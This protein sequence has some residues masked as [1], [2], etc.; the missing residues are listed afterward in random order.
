MRQRAF[1]LVELLV[2]IAIIGLLASIVLVV[3]GSAREKA[4]IAK[5][6]QFASNI[7]QVLG[8]EAAGIWDFDD[9]QDPTMDTSGSGNDGTIISAVFIDDTPSN[10]GHALSFN[11]SGAYVDCGNDDSLNFG[12]GDFTISVWVKTSGGSESWAGIVHKGAIT[13]GENYDPA[14]SIDLEYSGSA[15]DNNNSFFQA[16]N[17]V[18]RAYFGDIQDGKWHHLVGVVE[19]GQAKTYLDTE[20]QDSAV[21]TNS[22]HSNSLIIGQGVLDRNF[23]GLIDQVMIFNKALTS[24]QIKQLYAEGVKERGLANANIF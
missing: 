5:G 22:D 8:L 18:D 9:Q 24:A 11:G 12:V 2:V 17:W 10:N 1:T 23:N 7:Y 6:L 14:Y 15:G 4:R 16:G 21:A 20:Y 3:L 13:A 19:S